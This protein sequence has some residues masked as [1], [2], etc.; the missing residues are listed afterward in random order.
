[1]KPGLYRQLIFEL[2][3]GPRL[4]S[5]VINKVDGAWQ[6]IEYCSDQLVNR[7]YG[8]KLDAERRCKRD[9]ILQII[10]EE[11]RAWGKDTIRG[12]LN[13]LSTK[14]Y[15]KFFKDAENYGLSSPS[16]TKYG[17]LCVE[18]MHLGTGEEYG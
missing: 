12:R 14:G 7:D 16:R 6:E 8:Q 2:R 18:D 11:A 15:V 17:F 13:V 5:K 4:R 3:N 1:M 9:V 10:Y